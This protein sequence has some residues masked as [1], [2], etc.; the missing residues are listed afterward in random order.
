MK[1]L[2]VHLSDIHI[3]SE[4]DQI[5]SRAVQIASAA[6]SAHIERPIGCL[7]ICTGDV[8]YSGTAT[9]YQCASRF[10]IKIRESLREHLGTDDIQIVAIP[11]NHDCDFSV[12]Q[13]ARDLLTDGIKITDNSIIPSSI[14]NVCIEPQ[15]YFR[16][17][18]EQLGA[19]SL[20]Y[21][22][23]PLCTRKSLTFDGKIIAISLL[24]TAW[25]SH[26]S[27]K[28]GSLQFPL[29]HCLKD[30]VQADLAI[31]LFH[32]PLNWLQADNSRKF[33]AYLERY[34][35]ILFT[36]HEHVSGAFQ[37]KRLDEDIS[38][39]YIEGGVLQDSKYK[40]MSVF[41]TLLIDLDTKEFARHQFL[42]KG[43]KYEKAN[44]DAIYEKFNRDNKI[45]SSRPDISRVF[46]EYLNDAGATLTHRYKGELKLEDIFV[47]PNLREMVNANSNQ[48]GIK[49]IVSAGKLSDLIASNKRG[50]IIGEEKSG[51][52]TL[53]KYWFYQ[54]RNIGYEPLIINAEEIHSAAMDGV[55]KHLKRII[56]NEYSPATVNDYMQLLKGKRAVL[57]DNFHLSPLNR[58]G[59]NNLLNVLEGFADVLIVFVDEFWELENF[60]GDNDEKNILNEYPAME[61]MELGNYHREQMIRKWLVA[62]REETLGENDFI[63]EV[64]N[65]KKLIDSLLGK[66]LIPAYPIFM[67]IFLQQIEAGVSLKTSGGSQGYLYQ[68]LINSSLAVIS[69]RIEVDIDIFISQIAYCFFVDN[70][71][72]I[73]EMRLEEMHSQYCQ[74]YKLSITIEKMTKSL[75]E[76]G[77]FQR[78]T[79]GFMF[80]YRYFYYYFTAKYMADN[81]NDMEVQQRLADLVNSIYKEESA[82]IIIFLTYLTK[83][84]RIIE[85]LLAKAR[86]VYPEVQP[87]DMQSHVKFVE[88]LQEYVP[89]VI[90][91]QKS[92]QEARDEI[93]KSLDDADESLR[94]M[95]GP[96][97]QQ[98]EKELG[99]AEIEQM[100]KINV[101]FKTIQVL[102]QVLRNFSGSLKGD[103]KHDLT[104]ECYTLGMR[105]LNASFS[106][107]A[108]NLDHV[109]NYVAD[110]IEALKLT[111]SANKHEKAKE[112]IATIVEVFSVGLV[113]RIAQSVGAEP[114]KLTYQEVLE[115]NKTLSVELIDLA[116]KLDHFRTFPEDE[117]ESVIKQT[118]TNLLPR[119]IIRRLVLHR[120]YMLPTDYDVKQR[121]IKKL[122]MDE[123][124]VAGIEFQ[125]KESKK[126]K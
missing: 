10:L 22:S 77:I 106:V 34:G 27:E 117:L 84:Q 5:L 28:Q 83:D 65:V 24:N 125:H 92:V 57:L 121:Y 109:T 93:H 18:V 9:Q 61:I 108:D 70:L 56:S 99:Q 79:I 37:S 105:T 76:A 111:D 15:K 2:I 94:H 85:A 88:K 42:L 13:S 41:N 114:L 29:A 35:D 8:A 97:Q 14:L 100:L 49:R 38:S 53:A 20:D 123:K 26:E 4:E 120:F 62:G 67:L 32:H 115:N 89:K 90:F 40:E 11:G 45:F 107:M 102:G 104:L 55:E 87:C 73:S 81:F 59:R 78:D 7:I 36:G 64:D 72:R 71:L 6:A 30:I 74:Q 91:N 19:I 31:S 82:N 43:D 48:S 98:F 116:I 23:T 112:L 39:I 103:I 110:K 47:A 75:I 95:K 113:R 33:R 69:K 101:A 80:K 12:D 16:S 58:K 118:T 51:K 44:D 86:S 52:S 54:L 66:N 50:L 21:T 68:S 119:I 122:G 1:L 17:F 126:K 96:I 60:A 46:E 3:K 25:I 124:R 63:H